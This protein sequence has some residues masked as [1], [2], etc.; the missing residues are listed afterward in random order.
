MSCYRIF[1]TFE[2]VDAF[3]LFLYSGDLALKDWT[4]LNLTKLYW[5][6]HWVSLEYLITTFL[7]FNLPTINQSIKSINFGFDLKYRVSSYDEFFDSR[8]ME[9]CTVQ[10]AIELYYFTEGKRWT[11][12]RQQLKLYL[13]A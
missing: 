1:D 13:R 10:N 9:A 8:L 7:I 4:V 2:V 12:A 3:L 6:L 5:M 11:H